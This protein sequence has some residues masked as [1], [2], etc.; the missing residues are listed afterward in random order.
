MMERNSFDRHN[1]FT[2]ALKDGEW[3]D[4][5]P[6]KPDDGQTI[7]NGMY[8]LSAKSRYFRFFSPITKLSDANLH[9]F[10][11]V[12]QQHHVAWIALAH[13][14]AEHPGVGIARFIRFQDQPQIA[15]FA[16][17]VIDSYQKRG[18]G[19][20]LMAVLY[21]LAQ[22]RDIKILRAFVLPENTVAMH[23]LERL[24]AVGK[25]ENGVC[26]MDI[27]VYNDWSS[28]P[29]SPLMQYFADCQ[30]QMKPLPDQ[31]PS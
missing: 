19:T 12:D 25:F 22:A 5:R 31:N 1:G 26:Q 9:Y 6:V 14:T 20:M 18:L 23:W 27:A 13:D 10:T 11:E 21:V 16:V 8:A 15:E 24:G 3:V 4:F 29:T 28:F 2:I 7:Q 30:R 17:T